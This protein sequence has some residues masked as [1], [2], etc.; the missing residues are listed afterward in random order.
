MKKTKR[1]GQYQALKKEMLKYKNCHIELK[2]YALLSIHSKGKGAPR[3]IPFVILHTEKIKNYL[4]ILDDLKE[5]IFCGDDS[6]I[7]NHILPIKQALTEHLDYNKEHYEDIKGKW[8]FKRKR[9]KRGN[10]SQLVRLGNQRPIIYSLVEYW[11]KQSY[12]VKSSIAEVASLLSSN[13]GFSLSSKVI[14]NNWRQHKA[15]QKSIDGNHS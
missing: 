9:W 7:K 13:Y 5:N 14:E 1:K 2:I 6:L 4:S 12:N 8:N 15:L 3:P 10:N 11:R